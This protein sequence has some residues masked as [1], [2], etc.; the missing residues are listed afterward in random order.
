MYRVDP[1][2]QLVTILFVAASIR[3]TPGVSL[4]QYLPISYSGGSI[5]APEYG[6]VNMPP[7]EGERKKEECI[8]ILLSV[9]STSIGINPGLIPIHVER[10]TRRPLMAA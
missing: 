6:W 1:G 2:G 8:S 4:I 7:Q 5:A 10:T 3:L 9:L